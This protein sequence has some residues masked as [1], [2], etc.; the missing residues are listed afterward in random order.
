MTVYH[1]KDDIASTVFSPQN[2]FFSHQA[3]DWGGLN[4]AQRRAG[5]KRRHPAWAEDR[6]AGFRLIL[7]QSAY[8]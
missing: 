4:A 8:Q 6:Q 2:A 3:K 1:H 5:A 7:A